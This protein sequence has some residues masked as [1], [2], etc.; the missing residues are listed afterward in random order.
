MSDVQTLL[1]RCRALGA[2]LFPTPDGKLKV[3]APVPLPEDLQQKL[4][5][6]KAEILTLLAQPQVP[7]WPCPRCGNP[8][9]IED[10]CLSL[11]G[12]HTLTLW[13]CRP[14]QTWG[15]TPDTLRQPPVWVSRK[16][17]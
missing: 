14:C 15:A 6:Y 5:C 11:D 17:Q 16:E 2:E 13:H 3:R 1:A 9:E 7:P 12:Q 10:V 8:A 4:K